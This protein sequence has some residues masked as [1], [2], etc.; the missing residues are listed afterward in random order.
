M[1][2]I[3]KTHWN[4]DIL[5][6]TWPAKTEC[7]WIMRKIRSVSFMMHKNNSKWIKD[8][9]VKPETPKLLK[10][11]VSCTYISAR[12]DFLHR[13]PFGHEWEP[14]INKC[15]LIKWKNFCTSKEIINQVKS[16]STLEEKCFSV[17]HWEGLVYR[18]YKDAK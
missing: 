3:P 2:K 17:K 18:I 4:K 9:N 5:F 13:T 14:T 6:K 1:A 12:K 7:L 16:R 15:N 10:R 11:N 8:L